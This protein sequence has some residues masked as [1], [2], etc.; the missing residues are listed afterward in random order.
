MGRPFNANSKATWRT[1]QAA[2]ERLLFKHGFEAM[3]LRQL[4]AESELKTG[5]LYNYFDSKS[6]FL[7]TNSH[8]Y[9]GKDSG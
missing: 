6:E 4:A 7:A 8:R 1:I 9:N 5:S 3:N 2:G